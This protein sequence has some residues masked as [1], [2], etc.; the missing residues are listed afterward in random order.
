MT[1]SFNGIIL[2]VAFAVTG[3]LVELTSAAP[4]LWF[5]S[6]AAFL[7][8]LV[9]LGWHKATPIMV[10]LIAI[11]MLSIW[12]DVLN[13]DLTEQGL[14]LYAVVRNQRDA[15]VYSSIALGALAL[16]MT[17]GQRFGNRKQEPS[18]SDIL[19]E[20]LRN[21]P[22]RIAFVYFVFLPIAIII[23]KIGNSFPGLSQPAYALS[24]L[25]FVLIYWLS[26]SVFIT[27]RNYVWLVAVLLCEMISGSTGGFSTGYTDGIFLVLIAIAES[28]RRLPAR[29]VV[30]ALGA[31]IV[32]I[33]LSLIWTG[34]KQEFRSHILPKESALNS[35]AWLVNKYADPDLATM[36]SASKL[37]ERVGYTQFYAMVLGRETQQFG[38]NYERAVEHILKPRLLFPDKATLDDSAQT[39]AVLGLRINTAVTSIGLGYV[40]E[41]HID[42]GFPGLLAPMLALGAIVGAI[43]SY[44]LSREAPMLLCKAFGVTCLFKSLRFES[45]IDKELGGLIMVFLV[46]AITLRFGKS[47]LLRLA[48]SD[49][50]ERSVVSR[51]AAPYEPAR[52]APR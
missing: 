22:K 25:R 52:F 24:M 51:C 49:Q 48:A 31:S 50:G 2:F 33:Y 23:G 39:N 5:N 44:F 16:G 18:Q 30:F 47:L 1:R 26:T 40:A 42:F 34:V 3:L 36:K 45:D 4:L 7:F 6:L 38:G 29:Q 21:S 19:A 12:A 28:K 17:A 41:A 9:V 46:M 11:N 35:V 15:I 37:L 43:Y 20:G 10:F 14:G 32:V 13:I 27:N 8:A